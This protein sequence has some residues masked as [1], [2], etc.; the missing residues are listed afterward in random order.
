MVHL[1]TCY[2]VYPLGSLSGRDRAPLP[3][4]SQPFAYSLDNL[5]KTM[6]VDDILGAQGPEASEI[7]GRRRTGLDDN[8]GSVLPLQSVKNHLA[9]SVGQVFA[10]QHQVE[11]VQVD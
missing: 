8:V 7:G 6:L 4:A 1:A 3:I 2:Q 10:N 9:S 11:G 5:G